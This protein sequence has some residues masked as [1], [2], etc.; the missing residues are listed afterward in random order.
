MC[1]MHGGDEKCNAFL[2]GICE[3]QSPT[4]R[5]RHRHEEN[6]KTYI[7]GTGSKGMDVI[8]E[9]MVSFCEHGN[10]IVDLLK[11]R[12]LLDWLHEC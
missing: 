9:K 1:F 8:Q 2:V 7:K 5:P 11:A 6:V 4:G 12:E 3:R 10:E